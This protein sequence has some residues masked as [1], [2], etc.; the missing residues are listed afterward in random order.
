MWKDIRDFY[1][2]DEAVASRFV[3]RNGSDQRVFL[4]SEGGERLLRSETKMPTRMVLCGVIALEKANSYHALAC[5]WRLSQQ[6]V[7]AM[8]KLGLKRRLVVSKEFLVRLLKEKEISL[9]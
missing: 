7:A 8:N 3:Q 6:G 1:G 4:L 2:F 5:P 9:S